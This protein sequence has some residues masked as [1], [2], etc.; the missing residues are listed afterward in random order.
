MFRVD[1]NVIHDCLQFLFGEIIGAELFEGVD[2]FFVGDAIEGRAE[3][4]VDGEEF[5]RG[6]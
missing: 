6:T 3:F 2:I 4:K 1:G 5:G